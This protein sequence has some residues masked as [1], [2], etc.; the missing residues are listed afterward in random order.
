MQKSALVT[1]AGSGIGRGLALALARRGYHLLLVGRDQTRLAGSAAEVSVFST[2]EVFC[3]D[4]A[5]PLA[6]SRLIE[7]VLARGGAPMLL[8]HNAA[9]MPY[10]DFIQRS[11][12]EIEAAFAVNLLAPADLTSRF[13]A[14]PVPPQGLIFVL[15]TAAR[16]PQPYNSLYSASKSGLRALAEALQV[17]FAGRARVCLA[18]PPLTESA[19]TRGF[20]SGA[21][22]V[23][24]ADALTVA[25]RIISAYEAGRDEIS[26]FDWEVLPSLFYRLA[27]GPF[28]WLLKAYRQKLQDMFKDRRA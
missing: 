20:E 22:P 28:R 24:K 13:C 18:Y 5:D 15:S 14:A 26:W 8:V 23:R 21:W 6:R 16:F 27:P 2:A 9:A 3:A 12:A 11:S 19:L 10:G 1:G 4:L 25:E 17:E 7:A